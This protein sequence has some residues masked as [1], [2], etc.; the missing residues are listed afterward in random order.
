[1]ATRYIPTPI[2]HRAVEHGGLV[3]LGGIVADDKSL[4]MKGQTE[5]ILAK[6]GTYLA[7]AGSDRSR[8]LAATIY[9]TDL[10]LKDEMNEAWVAWFG[11]ENLPA[12]ATVGVAQ[13]GKDTLLEVVVTAYVDN[14]R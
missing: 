6:L 8:V 13:L 7:Q 3:F 10:G 12:R 2:M 11:A 4:G 1:M 5:Q 9:V 14:A